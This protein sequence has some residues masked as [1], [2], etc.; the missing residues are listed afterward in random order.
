MARGRNRDRH[1]KDVGSVNAARGGEADVL[2]EAA[3][4]LHALHCEIPP[5]L[6]GLG[7]KSKSIGGFASK[8]SNSEGDDSNVEAHVATCADE[9]IND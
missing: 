2:A 1:G 6:A 4:L 8:L 3:H 7:R 9:L 5:E